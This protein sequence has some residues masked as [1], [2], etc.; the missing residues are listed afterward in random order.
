MK[1]RKL[2][3]IMRFVHPVN[4][5][6]FKPAPVTPTG[7]ECFTGLGYI[8]MSAVCYGLGNSFDST[9]PLTWAQPFLLLTGFAILSDLN[10]QSTA[11]SA[12]VLTYAIATVVGFQGMFGYPETTTHDI[13]SIRGGIPCIPCIC[14]CGITSYVRCHEACQHPS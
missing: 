3:R 7:S 1:L 13:R 10:A 12:T 14:T 2:L 11:A 9:S 6:Q 5:V 4:I 8:V